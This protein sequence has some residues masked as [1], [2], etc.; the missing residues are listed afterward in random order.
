ME[1]IIRLLILGIWGLIFLFPGYA[2]AD[3]PVDE[4]RYDGGYEDNASKVAVDSSG[5][6]YVTGSSQGSGG[7]DYVTVKY[8]EKGK[9]LWVKRYDGGYDDNVNSLVVDSAGNVYVAGTSNLDYALVKYNSNGNEL[10]IKRYDGGE[11]DHVAGLAIDPIGNVYVTG[12]TRQGPVIGGWYANHGYTTIKYDANGNE[13]W[14][15]RYT[16][17]GYGVAATAIAV[18]TAGNVYITG[19]NYWDP[20]TVKYDTNGNELWVNRH[21]YNPVKLI[22]DSMGNIYIAGNSGSWPESQYAT[23]KY[24]ANGNELWSRVKNFG[25]ASNAT[26]LALDSSGNV[27][28]TGFV[29]PR[30]FDYATVKYDA[31]GNELWV[32]RYEGA[33]DKYRGVN[34]CDANAYASDIVADLLGNIYV[35]GTSY[36]RK[37]GYDFT[38]IKYTSKLQQTK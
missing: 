5:N 16:T 6:V 1:K 15:K 12:T 14:S 17:D 29:A 7:Y 13:L 19:G 36:S 3:K 4:L 18:D 26:A 38:T 30:P 31:N 21:P 9:E 2:L 10:W 27:Y 28:V 22:A 33:C 23:W 34:A 37:G 25:W 24:D 20:T 8:D 35:T 32:E 11:Q